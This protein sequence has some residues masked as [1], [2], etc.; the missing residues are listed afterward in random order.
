M[1]LLLRGWGGGGGG[2]VKS[3]NNFFLAGTEGAGG[4]AE[5]EGDIHIT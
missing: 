3:Y 2:G 5:G 1:C 4:A